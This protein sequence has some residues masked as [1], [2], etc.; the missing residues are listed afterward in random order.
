MQSHEHKT[1]D[2]RVCGRLKAKVPGQRK[3]L[4]D[5]ARRFRVVHT[6]L[7]LRLLF[8]VVVTAESVLLPCSASAVG[9]PARDA[10]KDSKDVQL[11]PSGKSAYVSPSLGVACGPSVNWRHSAN[12]SGWCTVAFGI[13]G[14][15]TSFAD[16]DP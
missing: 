15:L 3:M 5:A 4:P 16:V 13:A 14:D 11:G 10:L 1:P 8:S 7:R 2:M 6:L 12:D 9:V